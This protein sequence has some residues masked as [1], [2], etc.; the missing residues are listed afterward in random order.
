MRISSKSKLLHLELGNI[1][2]LQDCMC[3]LCKKRK[4]KVGVLPC[5]RFY[6]LQLVPSCLLMISCP[7]AAAYITCRVRPDSSSLM[8]HQTGEIVIL[9]SGK[10]ADLHLL[11]WKIQTYQTCVA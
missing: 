1:E 2:T 3:H 4:R 6:I 8:F 10:L 5:K 9:N 11:Y 7:Y